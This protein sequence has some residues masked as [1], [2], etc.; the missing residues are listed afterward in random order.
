MVR[1]IPD[2]PEAFWDWVN[3]WIARAPARDMTGRDIVWLGPYAQTVLTFMHLRDAGFPCVLTSEL[4]SSGIVLAH[5]DFWPHR[6]VGGG[7]LFVVEI[8]PDRK[9]TARR[10]DFVIV[11]S[12]GDPMFRSALGR[13]GSVAFMHFWPQ[14]GIVPRDDSRQGRVETACYMGNAQNMLDAP[15]RARLAGEL[16]GLGIAFSIP[17]IPAWHDFSRCDLVVAVRHLSHFRRRADPMFDV[18]RKPPT[19]LVNAW[20]AGVP[21]I[22][23][24]DPAYE[25]IRTSDLDYIR[26][27]G[28]REIVAAAKSLQRDPGLYDAMVANGRQR[29]AEFG[30]DRIV[31]DWRQVI[32]DKIVPHFEARHGEPPPSWRTM[33][34]TALSQLVGR[35]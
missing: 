1:A 14:P 21:A 9:L 34:R 23:S 6:Q 25:A 32:D 2:R 24:P 7:G 3:H 13:K 29:M 18:A 10:P 5:S 26:A 4:P 8:K 19:K 28:V 12:A 33:M 27:T 30:I 31:A 35:A 17:E 20:I 16:R 11:Q 22:L 15:D